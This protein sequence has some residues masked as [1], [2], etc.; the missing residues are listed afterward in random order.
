MYNYN[1]PKNNEN[2]YTDQVWHVIGWE[3]ESVLTFLQNY[4]QVVKFQ[5][6]IFT[7]YTLRTL[8]QK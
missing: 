8:F 3:G 6:T 5:I 7:F 4:Y 2:I 1:L